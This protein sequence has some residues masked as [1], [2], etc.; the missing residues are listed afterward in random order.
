VGDLTVQVGRL[1]DVAVHNAQGSH[2]G[3]GD[4]R[5]CWAPEAAGA[6][7]ED[8]GGLEPL[9]AWMGVLAT[10]SSSVRVK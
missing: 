2:S 9:L 4:V 3:P 1:D 7:D 10:C 8:L 6:D 5:R